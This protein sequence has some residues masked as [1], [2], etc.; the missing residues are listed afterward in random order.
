MRNVKNAVK[1]AACTKISLKDAM[2]MRVCNEE[3]VSFAKAISSTVLQ[4][5]ICESFG[6]H[7]A[8][9]SVRFTAT[10]M[11]IAQIAMDTK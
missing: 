3:H 7:R 6:I 8:I 10:I 5:H 9:W 2:V 1:C 4:L 11:I